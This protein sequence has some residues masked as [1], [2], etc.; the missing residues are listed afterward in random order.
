MAVTVLLLRP[1]QIPIFDF[2]RAYSLTSN[3]RGSQCPVCHPD[4]LCSASRNLNGTD[5]HRAA[6]L[7]IQQ[8]NPRSVEGWLRRSRWEIYPGIPREQEISVRRLDPRHEVRQDSGPVE[9]LH[10][11]SGEVSKIVALMSSSTGTTAKVRAG[12]IG[13][14]GYA[15]RT[16][17]CCLSTISGT[18]WI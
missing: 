4:V 9:I 17:Y 2:T 18:L 14:N 11:Q 8:V 16:S 7:G 1:V 12:R 5:C 13:P 10:T 6:R 3:I 15:V